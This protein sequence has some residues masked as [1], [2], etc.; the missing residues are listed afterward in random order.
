MA[1]N[2][3]IFTNLCCIW[4]YNPWASISKLVMKI[5]ATSNLRGRYIR[6]AEY[7]FGLYCSKIQ[8]TKILGLLFNKSMS[9]DSTFSK[10]VWGR[11]RMSNQLW[12]IY[13]PNFVMFSFFFKRDLVLWKILPKITQLRDYKQWCRWCAY[14]S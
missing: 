7:N 9:P 10:V 5:H 3:L 2:L 13:L 11:G 8:L 4:Y 12:K 1:E 14:Y 6:T